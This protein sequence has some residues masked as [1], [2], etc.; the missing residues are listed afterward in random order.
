MNRATSKTRTARAR[1]HRPRMKFLMARRALST[2]LMKET[3][4]VIIF[5]CPS[6]ISY[7]IS[8]D[9]PMTVS[10]DICDKTSVAF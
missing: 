3:T 6:L 9:T 5:A 1:N 7:P 8:L 2:V 4:V 10:G